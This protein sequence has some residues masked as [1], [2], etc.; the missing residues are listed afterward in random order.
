MHPG[1]AFPGAQANLIRAIE[2]PSIDVSGLNTHE[3]PIIQWWQRISSH[4]ALF[5]S[6]N[7]DNSIPT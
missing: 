4:A 1:G 2:G 5:I 7:R 6:W 3:G